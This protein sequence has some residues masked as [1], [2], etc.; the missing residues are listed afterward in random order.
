MDGIYRAF[1][2][3]QLPV[4]GVTIWAFDDALAVRHLHSNLNMN[5]GWGDLPTKSAFGCMN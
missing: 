4:I 2:V 5:K 1:K 3:T